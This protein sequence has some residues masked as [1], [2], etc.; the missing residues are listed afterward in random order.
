MKR[1]LT[2]ENPDAPQGDHKRHKQDSSP[3]YPRSLNHGQPSRLRRYQYTKFDHRGQIRLLKVHITERGRLCGS[4]V[5]NGL[6]ET[7]SRYNAISYCWGDKTCAGKLWFDGD[8]YLNLGTAAKK[9]LRYRAKNFSHEYI[10]IDTVCIDQDNPVEKSQQVQKMREIYEKAEK[11]IVWLDYTKYRGWGPQAISYVS[12]VSRMHRKLS[13]AKS[14]LG[15]PSMDVVL[16]GRILSWNLK[17]GGLNALGRLV[18]EP[19]FSRTWVIQEVVSATS[20]YIFCDGMLLKWDEFA[21]AVTL[22]DKYSFFSRFGYKRRKALPRHFPAHLDAVSYIERLRRR[23]AKGLPLHIT[24]LLIQARYAHST[25]DVDKIYALR[26]LATDL[27]PSELIVD[28]TIPMRELYIKATRFLLFRKRAYRSLEF[29]GTWK[30]KGGD[31]LPSWVIDFRRVSLKGIMIDPGGAR[32]GGTLVICRYLAGDR[33]G[34][35][36]HIISKI[37]STIGPSDQ[38]S[39]DQRLVWAGKIKS[40]IREAGNKIAQS[41]SK[42]KAF[43]ETPDISLATRIPNNNSSKPVLTNAGLEF[44]NS[45]HELK[46]LRVPKCGRSP[47]RCLDKLADLIS[48]RDTPRRLFVSFSDHMGLA[49]TTA[50]DEDLVCVL[51]GF[52][53]P[54]ILR[55]NQDLD[56]GA[57]GVKTYTLIGEAFVPDLMNGEGLK[58]GKPESIIL[59]W[60]M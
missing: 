46:A 59:G 20:A 6:N 25:K 23:K 19:Y 50:E 13:S 30:H 8:F 40:W 43:D 52:K 42:T 2:L 37:A 39:K 56:A 36:G 58:I 18:C 10:W 47:D 33:L 57:A 32:A 15:K 35:R 9:I 31:S 3:A 16:K 7:T 29:A 28:Y 11:V 53:V 17:Y 26:G 54:F 4:F 27:T 51:Y 14:S 21:E 49:P 1:T 22:S 60:P 48:D 34:V 41:Q 24:D 44:Q 55:Q 45:V 5:Y 38:R 12:Y